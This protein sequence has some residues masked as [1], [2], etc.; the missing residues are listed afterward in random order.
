MSH[1]DSLIKK[2]KELS[3]PMDLMNVGFVGVVGGGGFEVVSGGGTTSTNGDYTYHTYSSPGTVNLVTTGTITVNFVLMG[4]GGSGRASWG[5]GGSGGALAGVTGS[6]LSAGTHA[7][8]VGAGGSVPTGSEGV[9]G[10][11][12]SFNGLTAEGGESAQGDDTLSTTGTSRNL[13]ADAN[14]ITGSTTGTRFDNVSL[15]GGA[16]QAEHYSS[17]GGGVGSAGQAGANTGDKEGGDGLALNATNVGHD[18]THLTAVGTGK[19]GAGGAG[20]CYISP[21]CGSGGSD[22]G[23]DYGGNGGTGHY[24]SGGTSGGTGTKGSGGGGTGYGSQTHGM[25]PGAGGDGIVVITY[26]TPT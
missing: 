4:G 19:W 20:G 12:S 18:Y 6:T 22:G 11:D 15:A 3:K 16:N 13:G 23:D 10:G 1:R 21:F 14:S 26:L 17:G 25:Y 8:V 9:A 5:A 24:N 2:N 7:V